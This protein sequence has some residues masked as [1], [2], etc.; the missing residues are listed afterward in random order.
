MVQIQVLSVSQ[1]SFHSSITLHSC[2]EMKISIKWEMPS[3][4]ILN[5]FLLNILGELEQGLRN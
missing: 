2:Y 4:H 3:R 5:T 1:T